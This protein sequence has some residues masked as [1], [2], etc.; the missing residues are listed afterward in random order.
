MSTF[1]W[2]VSFFYISRI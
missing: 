2:C 1:L